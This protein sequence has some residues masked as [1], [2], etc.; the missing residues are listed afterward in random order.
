MKYISTSLALALLLAALPAIAP[1]QTKEMTLLRSNGATVTYALDRVESVAFDDAQWTS[2]GYCLYGEDLVASVLAPSGG[3][4]GDFRCEYYVEVQEKNDYPGYYR[5]VNPYGSAYPFLT[6]SSFSTDERKDYY[7]EIDATDP[8]AVIIPLQATGLYVK[9]YGDFSVYS[10]AAYMM[11]IYGYT[12]SRAKTEGLCGTL[13]DGRITFPQ[14]MLLSFLS[15]STYYDYAFPGNYFNNFF[16]DLNDCIAAP[17]A[18]TL[19]QEAADMVMRVSRDNGT[20]EYAVPS[21]D[22][23]KHASAPWTSI[24]YCL[25]G[26]DFIGSAIYPAGVVGGYCCEYY[27]EVEENTEQPGLYCLVNPY[28]PAVYPIT[29]Y[30]TYDDTIDHYIEIDATDPD[31][32]FI[33][34]QDTGVEWDIYGHIWAYSLAGYAY[35]DGMRKAAVA[36][37]GYF[38]TMKNGVITFGTSSLLVYLRS[39]YPTSYLRGNINNYFK[40][41]LND[42]RS[43]PGVKSVTPIDAARSAREAVVA[44]AAADAPSAQAQEQQPDVLLAAPARTLSKPLVGR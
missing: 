2:L 28:A 29:G 17:T 31:A 37:E 18:S 6:S 30:G 33:P 19:G 15:C 20:A 23:V 3:V 11:D 5:L 12:L 8:E 26:E 32:V 39:Y 35:D 36:E 16:L 13:K 34:L 24:G 44:P 40:L 43:A 10:Y 9:S 21:V 42:R 25:Y 27:V 22:K 38:G 1:A 7:L 14:E 41:N 4:L